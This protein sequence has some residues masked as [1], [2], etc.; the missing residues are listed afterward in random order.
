MA[1]S[2]GPPGL[3]GNQW[4]THKRKKNR[5]KAKLVKKHKQQQRRK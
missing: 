2:E 5:K 3:M 4:F 1:R